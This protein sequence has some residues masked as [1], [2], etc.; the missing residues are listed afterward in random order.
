M[1]IAVA[2]Q[3]EVFARKVNSKVKI[4]GYKKIVFRNGETHFKQSEVA[5]NQF[6][7][8]V[9]DV[10]FKIVSHGDGSFTIPSLSL[11]I[12]IRHMPMNTFLFSSVTPT[13]QLSI[14][15]PA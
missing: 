7:H 2:F 1:M 8:F 5:S 6:P 13:I 15:A 11:I 14:F 12:T 4:N 9:I 3:G 10:N